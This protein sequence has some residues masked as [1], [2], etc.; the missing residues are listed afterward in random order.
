MRWQ[1]SCRLGNATDIDRLTLVVTPNLVP[2]ELYVKACEVAQKV[3]ADA[4]TSM[5]EGTMVIEK[6][7]QRVVFQ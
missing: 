1:R 6:S 3:A 2:A 5:E 4:K 7:Q